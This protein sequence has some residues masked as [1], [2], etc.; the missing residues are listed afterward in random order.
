MLSKAM[1]GL[2]GVVELRGKVLLGKIDIVV[3]GYT[4]PR[5]KYAI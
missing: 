4:H 1:L 3:V 2:H 5:S